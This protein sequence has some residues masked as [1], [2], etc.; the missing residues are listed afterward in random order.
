MTIFLN[1]KQTMLQ[2]VCTV[3]IW[4]ACKYFA[5]VHFIT[6]PQCCPKIYDKS[7]LAPWR[8]IHIHYTL[9]YHPY[10]PFMLMFHQHNA[11]SP[12]Q[13][14]QGVVGYSRQYV[15]RW[16]FILVSVSC[17]CQFALNIVLSSCLGHFKTKVEEP[18]KSY[19]ECNILAAFCHNVHPWPPTVRPD[20]SKYAKLEREVTAAA[21]RPPQLI[22][23]TVRFL[24]FA[25]LFCNTPW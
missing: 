23:K 20:R 7:Q 2:S 21:P 14:T 3:Y 18:L 12:V 15:Q 6:Y 16:G 13:C 1:W 22:A 24:T 8:A 9:P 5:V 4:L 25:D 19:W 17:D 11:V 10:N